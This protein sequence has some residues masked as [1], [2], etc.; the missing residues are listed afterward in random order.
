MNS[1]NKLERTYILN[2]IESLRHGRETDAVEALEFYRG[3]PEI[4][5]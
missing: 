5:K 3:N 4:V 1:I 2:N